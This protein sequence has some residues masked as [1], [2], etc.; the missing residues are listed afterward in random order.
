LDTATCSIANNNGV[1]WFALLLLIQY[2]VW[3]YDAQWP[4]GTSEAAFGM[5]MAFG[6]TLVVMNFLLVYTV[7]REKESERDRGRV[8][9][10]QQTTHAF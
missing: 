1:T 4:L 2:F 10:A 7:C 3:A 5:Y 8:H 6:A 9:N